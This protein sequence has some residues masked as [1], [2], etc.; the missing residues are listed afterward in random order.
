MVLVLRR[1]MTC[2]L[3][4]RAQ[5]ESAKRNST[6][7]SSHTFGS[8][9]RAALAALKLLGP[10]ARCARSS[11]RA[12][13]LSSTAYRRRLKDRRASRRGAA[14]P[15]RAPPGRAARI[16]GRAWMRHPAAGWGRRQGPR[17]LG[18]WAGLETGG[19]PEPPGPRRVHAARRVAFRPPSWESESPLLFRHRV[20]TSSTQKGIGFG[21]GFH[22]FGSGSGSG[23]ESGK[24]ARRD[25][26]YL[27]EA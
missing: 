25:V 2:E 13:E 14:P 6:S 18:V 10:R 15:A 24:G 5:L 12:P 22:A 7:T 3:L 8:R 26:W 21:C 19:P 20:L 1:W 9:P 23:D 11:G 4:E 27:S 17:T 16:G